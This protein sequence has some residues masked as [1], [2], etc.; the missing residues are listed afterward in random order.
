MKTIHHFALLLTAVVGLA[1]SGCTNAQYGQQPGY[2]DHNY[3]NPSYSNQGYGQPGY[4]QPGYGNQPYPNQQ[5][6]PNQSYNNQPG[7][8]QPGYDNP[9]FYSS[10]APYGQWVQTPEY[11]TVWIPQVTPGF[12]PYATNGHWVITDY[13][14]TWVSDYAWGWAPFHYG[15]WYYD[16]YRGWAW[17]P[18]TDWGPAWVSWRTGGGYYGWAPLGPGMN[19]GVNVNI[20]IAPNFWT[21]VPQIYITSPQVYS[22]YVP[23]PQVINIY[24]NTT[25]INNIYRANNRD[26]FYGP[27]RNEIERITRRSVPV[28]RIE[29]QD[30]PGRYDIQNGAVRI[31]QPDIARNGRGSYD[32]SGNRNGGYNNNGG[33][34]QNGRGTNTPNTGRRDGVY[35]TPFDNRPPASSGRGD[36][37]GN[38]RR[39]NTPN[40]AGRGTYSAPFDNTPSAT[41][42]AGADRSGRAYP[43]QGYP[44]PTSGSREG[45]TPGEPNRGFDN[46][47]SRGSYT[48][49]ADQPVVSTPAPAQPT[50]GFGRGNGF[51]GGQPQRMPDNRGGS[52]SP[53]PRQEQSQPQQA[54]QNQGRGSYQPPS[55]QQES[56]ARPE[57]GARQEA[58]P[59]PGNAGGGRGGRGPR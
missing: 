59:T 41:P 14:N 54:P 20:N 57:Q 37:S 2:S 35:S 50:G 6:Y 30:R 36:A 23:R 22:Y 32:P 3:G 8:G 34:N 27:N 55:R 19:V 16:N 56:V 58:A 29:R 11:G 4:G 49:P 48:P 5:N 42:N 17:V 18:G 45:A 25:Y 15:R 13:G 9:D 1:S 10:L 31:Y 38:D 21:F 51:D 52:S 33:Y 24:Q 7:Y 28:Y 40:G 12:Q 44:N 26:Y 47:R 43:G 53:Q 46:G 39:D